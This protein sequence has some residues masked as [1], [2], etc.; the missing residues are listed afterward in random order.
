MLDLAKNQWIEKKQ[1]ILITEGQMIDEP[2]AQRARALLLAAENL[3][4]AR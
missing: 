3:Q 1:N 4:G 2:L